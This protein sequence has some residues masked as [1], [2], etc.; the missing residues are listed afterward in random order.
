MNSRSRQGETQLS[1]PLESPIADEMFE[2]D[3]LH[4]VHICARD[5]AACMLL[6]R[7]RASVARSAPGTRAADGRP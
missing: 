4:F 2:R 5:D 1:L 7:A 6:E 3:S